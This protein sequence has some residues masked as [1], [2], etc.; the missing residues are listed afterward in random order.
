ML[1]IRFNFTANSPNPCKFGG[2]CVLGN[3]GGCSCSCVIGF[4]GAYC[5]ITLTKISGVAK[6][7]VFPPNESKTI[8]TDNMEAAVSYH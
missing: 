3:D 5:E 2:K 4:A 7:N 6:Y 1:H 8:E